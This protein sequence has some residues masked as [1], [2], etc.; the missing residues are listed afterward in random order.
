ME[1]CAREGNVSSDA[2]VMTGK[3]RVTRALSPLRQLSRRSEKTESEGKKETGNAKNRKRHLHFTSI[4][5]SSL[6][7]RKV[8]AWEMRLST[9][10]WVRIRGISSLSMPEKATSIATHYSNENLQN[11]KQLISDCFIRMS[12]RYRSLYGGYGIYRIPTV[13]RAAPGGRRSQTDCVR[14]TTTIPPSSPRAD[15]ACG[16]RTAKGRGLNGAKLKVVGPKRVGA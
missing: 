5:T 7:E 15:A 8:R 1:R 12:L 13:S 14:P 16:C 2:M 4:F 11:T 10:S 9:S 6:R 3:W